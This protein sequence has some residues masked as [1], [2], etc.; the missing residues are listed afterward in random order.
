MSAE[1]SVAT[2]RKM[3]YDWLDSHRPWARP[4]NQGDVYSMMEKLVDAAAWCFR[5]DKRPTN[6]EVR[7]L[8]KALHQFTKPLTEHPQDYDGPCMCADCRND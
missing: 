2:A 7:R 5:A 1:I 3:F 4:E 8:E 6:E